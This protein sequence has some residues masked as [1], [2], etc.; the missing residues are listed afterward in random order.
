VH[1]IGSIYKRLYKD[2]RS[3]KHKKIPTVLLTSIL[4]GARN[5]NHWLHSDLHDIMKFALQWCFLWQFL[6]ERSPVVNK[7]LHVITL[8]TMQSHTVNFGKRTPKF[9]R[10]MS[11]P[12]P[13]YKG[14]LLYLEPG[15]TRF[16]ANVSAYVAKCTTS[17][18][19]IHQTS[20]QN[21]TLIQAY[22]YVKNLYLLLRFCEC[23]GLW[24]SSAYIQGN[25]IN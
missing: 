11:C 9:Q 12:S 5:E 25:K 10:N 21:V 23:I 17:H 19:R 8:V 3:T 13:G 18:P 22:R 14:V 1:Q 20:G 16:V 15:G 4:K 24:E 2:A 7:G 6:Q